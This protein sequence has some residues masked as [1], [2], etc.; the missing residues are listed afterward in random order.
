MSTPTAATPPRVWEPIAEMRTSGPGT[1][2]GNSPRLSE[3]GS[4]VI[5]SPKDYE[6]ARRARAFAPAAE[7]MRDAI[8][9]VMS[10]H[11]TIAREF[12]STPCDCEDCET[13]RAAL[14]K[15]GARQARP[16]DRHIAHVCGG[17][18]RPYPSEVCLCC[19]S[20]ESSENLSLR[21]LV[22]R[23][24]APEQP[25]ATGE[26]GGLADAIRAIQVPHPIENPRDRGYWRTGFMKGLEAAA[27][28]ASRAAQQE[29]Q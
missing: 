23:L 3:H 27:A 5:L 24:N 9:L 26:T 17:Q 18:V 10:R 13:F 19:P 25:Q 14:E 28:L 1:G 12:D 4:A 22:A 20:G 8:S 21:D 7:A 11:E 29:K 6:E 2:L 15:I 16:S